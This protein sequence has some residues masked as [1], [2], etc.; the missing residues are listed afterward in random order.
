MVLATLTVDGKS[1]GPHA[2]L[3]DLRREGKLV[4]GV[5]VGDMGVKTTG[6]D[7]DNAWISFDQAC[8]CT[9]YSTVASTRHAC[10]LVTLL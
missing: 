7:L 9:C 3:M 6:N 10:A 8:M 1:V 4:A 5:S 2:F